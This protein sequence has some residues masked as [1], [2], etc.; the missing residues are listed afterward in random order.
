MTPPRPRKR[1]LE[2]LEAIYQEA[3]QRAKVADH[4][5]RMLELDASFQREQLLME[6]LLD[7]RDGL[8]AIA[9]AETESSALDKLKVLRRLT[10][11]R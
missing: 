11:L 3:Y 4:D 5:D 2:N 7:I 6:I 1:I 9:D 8:Y 10:K